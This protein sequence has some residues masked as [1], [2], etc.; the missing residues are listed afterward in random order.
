ML[1]NVIIVY[2]VIYCN[3]RWNRLL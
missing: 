1:K 2:I 3:K